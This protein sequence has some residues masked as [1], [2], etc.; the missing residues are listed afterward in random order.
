MVAIVRV[1]LNSYLFVLVALAVFAARLYG[2]LV[3]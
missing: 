1:F 2:Y 3:Y